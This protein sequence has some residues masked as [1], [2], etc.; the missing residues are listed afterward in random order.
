MLPRRAGLCLA[1][2][3]ATSVASMTTLSAQQDSTRVPGRASAPLLTGDRFV[4][5]LGAA[6]TV[7][8]V[9]SLL[10]DT[11]ARTLS[12][13]LTGRV[14]GVEVLASSGTIG[15]GSRILIR[16]VSSFT[17][18]SAPQ[19][20]LDGIR[21]DD[22]TA[23]LRVDVGGQTTSRVDDLDVEDIATI[24]ILPGPAAAALYGTDAA[25]GVL[26]V[27]SKQGAVG[28]SRVRAFSSQGLVA[29]PLSFPTNF[30]AVSPA[31]V[32]CT[33]AGVA[34]GACSLLTSNVLASPA[35]SPFRNGYLRQYGVRVGGGDETRRYSLSGQWDGFGGV[36]GLSSAEQT[37]LAAAGGLHPE[38]LN[39]NYLRQLGRADR[40]ELTATGSFVS[41]D[42]RLPIN[43]RSDFGI[44]ASGLL[45]DDTAHAGWTSYFPGQ[46]FQLATLQHVERVTGTLAST[47]RPLARVTVRAVIGLDR[48]SQHD[49]QW[50]RPGEGPNGNPV[51]SAV[52]DGTLHS[53]RYT[54]TVTAAG[55]WG[56]LPDL[57]MR[58]TVGV[59]HFRHT[60]EVRD[61]SATVFGTAYSYSTTRLRDRLATTALL[62]EQQLVWRERLFLTGT[63]RR[64]TTTRLVTTDPA[65]MYPGVGVVWRARI[66]S[67]GPVG[68]VRLRAAWGAAGR[69]SA[70]PE[71]FRFFYSLPPS[72]L[73]PTIRPERTSEW[74]VGGDAELFGG[75]LAFTA[76]V[77]DK[78]TTDLVTATVPAPSAGPGLFIFQGG[79]VANKGVELTLSTSLLRRPTVTWHIGL[80]AWGNRN[81]VLQTVGPGKNYGNATVIPQ[82][83]QTGLPLGSYSGIPILGYADTNGD[84]LLAPS[85]I[86][87]GPTAVFLGTP[88]P[89]QGASLTSTLTLRQC[90]RIA[91]LV[92]YRAGQSLV[93]G[94][95][96]ARCAVGSCRAA[97]DP[98]TPLADQVAW[99]AWQA[100]TAAGWVQRANFLKLRDVSIT[101]T[102]PASWAAHVAASDL[103]LT[104]T[105]RNLAMWT[106]YKGLD[107]EVNAYGPEGLAVADLFTQPQARY[108]TARLDLSF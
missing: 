102:M 94:T 2:V 66:G 5:E 69:T 65:V 59:Q 8:D 40:A 61:S 62:V 103:R 89:T 37:R 87:L 88:F 47:W 39:P 57:S 100:G 26:L 53:N 97:V 43:D 4:S 71:A 7:L 52:K 90:V 19:I 18:T 3:S 36:Y 9:D 86:R 80:S 48:A 73:F 107:P 98:S 58:T 77:Y 54:G 15:T 41:S 108:W 63:L 44:L 64:E 34:S 50:Q 76:T 70:L 22:E 68:P 55:M 11:P 49:G 10:R 96:E 106:S 95:E 1:V 17:Q 81:R 75:R 84:G 93:N 91:A 33:P 25:N 38:V 56:P 6:V 23:T 101:F 12:E 99:A 21:V 20:Y 83:A 29:Q 72:T 27:T 78:R 105:G 42:L 74:E 32:P 60:I 31:G 28:R 46:I 79:E 67:P 35:S 14:P 104:L 51:F 24:T 13:L 92:E 82:V 85:E 30:R 16:G 45:G